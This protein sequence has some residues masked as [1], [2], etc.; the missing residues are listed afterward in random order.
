VSYSPGFAAAITIPNLT[1]TVRSHAG[2][3]VADPAQ[4][5]PNCEHVDC[6]AVAPFLDVSQSVF[7]G[8]CETQPVDEPLQEWMKLKEHLDRLQLQSPALSSFETHDNEMLL[9]EPTSTLS[10]ARQLLSIPYT[11]G[12]ATG[13]RVP[14]EES[15]HSHSIAVH[16]MVHNFAPRSFKEAS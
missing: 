4:L 2:F 16:L 14:H 11:A 9:Q 5:T 15:R 6:F 10:S 7:R 8:C 3:V 1:P 13:A 12:A